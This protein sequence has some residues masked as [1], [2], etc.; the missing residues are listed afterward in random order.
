MDPNGIIHFERRYPIRAG[1]VSGGRASYFDKH[2]KGNTFLT[3]H[4]MI[5]SYVFGSYYDEID[6]ARSHISSVFGTWLSRSRQ[7]PV[8]LCRFLHDQVSL[9]SDISCELS[10]ARPGLL[11]DL[12]ALYLTARGVP[13]R[14]QIRSISQA[15]V[16]LS[17]TYMPPKQVYSAII[18]ARS[19]EAWYRPFGSSPVIIQLVRDIRLMI[20]AIP[21]H[22]LCVPFASA[23]RDAGSGPVYIISACL[24]HLD[25]AALTAA[26]DALLLIDVPSSLTINDSLCITNTHTHSTHTILS[27]A[28]QAAS[29]RVG[30]SVDFKHLPGLRKPSEP[31]RGTV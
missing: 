16:A 2:G 9:E 22:P 28:A 10:T 7:R 3:C 13:S 4:D 27:T 29:L 15:Q 24:A 18:N 25:D 5:R 6:I 17:K 23:L 20:A 31:Q 1:T 19:V 8:S 26:A 30:Y 14:T 11:A 12:N 21:R